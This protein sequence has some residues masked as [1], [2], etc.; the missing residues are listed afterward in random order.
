M[1]A[2]FDFARLQD[3]YLGILA[4]HVSE[5]AFGG[6]NSEV[7]IFCRGSHFH[8]RDVVSRIRL[9]WRLTLGSTRSVAIFGAC[10]QISVY[11]GC[12]PVSQVQG[13][14]RVKASPSGRSMTA[15]MESEKTVANA[16]QELDDIGYA[17]VCSF[18]EGNM[19]KSI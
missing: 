8:R 10:S 12:L 15:M 6:R 17:V 16:W 13:V 19:D 9:F 14:V 11:Q 5:V 18:T 7:S 2:Q 3:T 4:V 1:L